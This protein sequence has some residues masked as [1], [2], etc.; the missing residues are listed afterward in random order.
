L[1]GR[2]IGRKT[3][4]MWIGRVHVGWTVTAMRAS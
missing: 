3:A 1:L 2:C 4:A